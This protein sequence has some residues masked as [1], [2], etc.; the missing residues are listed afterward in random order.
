MVLCFS[1]VEEGTK[2][3]EGWGQ[4]RV[5]P[6]PSTSGLLLAETTFCLL[7]SFVTSQTILGTPVLSQD[8][9]CRQ[10]LSG[11]AMCLSGYCVFNTGNLGQVA[12]L[13]VWP[14]QWSGQL[15]SLAKISRGSRKGLGCAQENPSALGE[16]G[17]TWEPL[18]PGSS[19]L[20]Q[21]SQWEMLLHVDRLMH[22]ILGETERAW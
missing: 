6:G 8:F 21:H 12:A 7:V 14:G 19:Q 3:G 10:L 17:A 16:P 13:R 2:L 15:L 22:E 4:G 1:T 11:R 9:L 20:L 18:V 5:G